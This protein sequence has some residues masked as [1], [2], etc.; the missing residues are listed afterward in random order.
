VSG[1]RILLPLLAVGDPCTPDPDT[2]GFALQAL[3]LVPGASAEVGT[4]TS[5]LLGAQQSDG[6]YLGAAGENTNSTALAVQG[7]LSSGN[8]SIAGAVAA[9]QGFLLGLQNSDGGFGVRASSPA[10]DPRPSTAAVPALVG[11]TLVTLSDPVVPVSP[12]STPP[13][14]TAPTSTA[15]ASSRPASPTP[16]APTGSS[17]S[18]IEPVSGA[19]QSGGELASTGASTERPLWLAVLLV[20]AGAMVLMLTRRTR[21]TRRR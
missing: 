17:A 14:S 9:A 6:G 13:T 7:L 5:Y 8:S 21:R 4:A 12:T 11:S 15:P 1:R 3:S 2:T 10:S 16:S 20:L 18:S 19:G